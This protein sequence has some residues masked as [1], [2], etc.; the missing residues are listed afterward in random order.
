MSIPGMLGRTQLRKQQAPFLDILKNLQAVMVKEPLR[1]C[2]D[3]ADKLDHLE[4][5]ISTMEHLIELMP[6]P[7]D[8][9]MV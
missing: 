1:N 3:F 8:T 6:F 2:D 9:V 4:L 5:G 7:H